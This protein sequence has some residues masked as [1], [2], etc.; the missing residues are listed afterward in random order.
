LTFVE[1]RSTERAIELS[2]V[3]A[4]TSAASSAAAAAHAALAEKEHDDPD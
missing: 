2:R 3:I 1:D 4:E